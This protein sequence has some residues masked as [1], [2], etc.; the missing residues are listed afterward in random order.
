MKSDDHESYAVYI[1]GASRGNP[2]PSGAGIVIEVPGGEKREVSRYLGERTNNQAEYEAFKLALE[3]LKGLG[4]RKACFYSDSE[5]L[6]RQLRAEYR[7]RNEGLRPLFGRV[8]SML[9]DLEAYEIELIDRK[10]NK[11][12]DQLA[13]FAID[14]EESMGT[15]GSS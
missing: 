7:I 2:G 12:A 9:S 3:E 8:L 14:R 15:T 4:V 13:N 5:L 10:S 11:R 6:V 1:D